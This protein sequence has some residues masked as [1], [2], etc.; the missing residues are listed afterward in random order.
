V[1]GRVQGVGFRWWTRR[2]ASALGLRGNVWNRKDGSVEIQA[3]GSEGALAALEMQ[4]HRGP[5]GS[6]VDAVDVVP[7]EGAIPEG[8]FRAEGR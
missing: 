8:G 2:C 6:C 1:T 5:V 3:E 4:L 7:P